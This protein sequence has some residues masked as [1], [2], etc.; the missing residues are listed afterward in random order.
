[1]PVSF[2]SR[3]LLDRESRYSATELECLAV[4]E[5]LRHLEVHLL[6]GR[7][8]IH[9]DH[10]ALTGLMKSTLLNRRLW[11]WALFLQDF[12]V[13]FEYRP[14]REN[15]VADGLSRQAWSDEAAGCGENTFPV[16]TASKR[17][18]LF[19]NE[20][21]LQRTFRR[22]WTWLLNLFWPRRS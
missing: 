12:N 16:I 2:F 18:R 17:S 4:V 3:Q 1:M 19:Q 20:W 14:G 15:A 21:I 6:G 11:R 8:V 13:V 5:A 10:K 9:P 22:T 7:F